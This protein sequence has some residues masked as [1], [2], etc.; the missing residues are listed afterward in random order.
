LR[1]YSGEVTGRSAETLD[2]ANL[3][4]DRLRSRR[5][6]FGGSLYRIYTRPLSRRAPPP[7]T[8]GLLAALLMSAPGTILPMCSWYFGRSTT[9]AVWDVSD[10]LAVL[11]GTSF[12][13]LVRTREERG[14]DRKPERLSGLEVYH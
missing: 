8:S 13:H 14:W 1:L 11:E 10:P 9:E 5:Q 2:E 6:P 12:D 3:G 4:Q 7:G